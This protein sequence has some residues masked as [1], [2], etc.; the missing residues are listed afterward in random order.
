M[1]GDDLPRGQTVLKG[2]RSVHDCEHSCNRKDHCHGWF[3]EPKRRSI[4]ARFSPIFP[5]FLTGCSVKSFASLNGKKR[6]QGREETE[7][8]EGKS[9]TRE[10]GTIGRRREE[11]KSAEQTL[12]SIF[13]I[14]NPDSPVFGAR[15]TGKTRTRAD[16]E[17]RSGGRVARS[18]GERNEAGGVKFIS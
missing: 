13:S 14:C 3:I 17:R 15:T 9:G 11:R 12:K 7:K 5:S 4:S 8:M 2:R 1:R 10:E 6:R 18:K 16:V